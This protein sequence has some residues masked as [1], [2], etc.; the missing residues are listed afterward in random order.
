MLS[1]RRHVEV[2]E[3][4]FPVNRTSPLRA[5]LTSIS[6]L[7]VAPTGCRRFTAFSPFPVGRFSTGDFCRDGGRRWWWVPVP[8]RPSDGCPAGW[9]NHRS[10]PARRDE[11]LGVACRVTCS[12]IMGCWVDVGGAASRSRLRRQLLIVAH[13]ALVTAVSQ[14][15][16]HGMRAVNMSV[17]TLW[18]GSVNNVAA[19]GGPSSCDYY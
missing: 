16:S 3:S 8:G 18:V 14:S 1:A 17:Q 13:W 12:R 5:S 11:T 7:G 9:H 15:V 4:S 2:E 10:L 6:P 19:T